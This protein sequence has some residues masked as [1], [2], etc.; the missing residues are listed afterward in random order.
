MEIE[1]KF[2]LRQ[3]P[4]GLEDCPHTSIEQAYLCTRP[5]VRVR[6]KGAEFWLTCKGEGLMAREEYELPLSEQAY[7]H[8]LSK[9][10]GRRVQKE[11]YR[12]PL[13]ELTVEVDLFQGELAPLILAAVEGSSGEQAEAFQ[14]PAWFGREVTYD[15]AYTNAYLSQQR[16]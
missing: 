11:R 1:R 13:G 6:R 12:V 2:L 3:L 16:D 7:L 15:P 8:L 14:P 10:D 9:A 4:E 5:V